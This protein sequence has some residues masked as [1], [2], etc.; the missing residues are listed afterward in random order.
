MPGKLRIGAAWLLVAAFLVLA[1]PTGAGLGAGAVVAAVGL[2][3]RAWAAGSLDKGSELATKGPYARTRNPLYVGSCLIGLGMCLTGGHWIWP[4]L[5][6]GF[7]V[8]FYV[9]TM[10]AEAAALEDRFG[11]RFV[12]YA[13]AVPAFIP[14]LTPYRSNVSDDG[15]G[16]RWDRYRRYREW[17]ATLGV[18]AVF[19]VLALKVWLTEL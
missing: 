9:P 14:R 13:A 15:H 5:F 1:R 10:R 11:D 8:S 7:F 4:A 19:A 16:F 3:L 2:W 17:E 6:L 12:A 18:L